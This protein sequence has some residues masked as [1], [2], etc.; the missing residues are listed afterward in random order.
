[1][2]DE[3]N[4]RMAD[5]TRK[6][7]DTAIDYKARCETLTK[8][9]ERLALAICG[10]EDAPGYANAQP[11]ET[12]EKVARDWGVGMMEQINRT[13]AL[14]AKLATCEKY[15][16][17]YADCDRIGTQAVRDLESKLA[18]VTAAYRLEA[19]RRD[20]YSHEDFEH[21]LAT[22]KGDNP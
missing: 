17:A 19:M 15:R 12:L 11:V 4:D 8:E 9:R 7:A 10:G 14:E 2:T 18:L 22:L 16:D 5:L 13:L 6:L 1:M 20:D 21:H 3:E